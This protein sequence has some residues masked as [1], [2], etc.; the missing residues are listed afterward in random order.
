MT[1][2]RIAYEAINLSR[3]QKDSPHNDEFLKDPLQGFNCRG[4]PG[5]LRDAQGKKNYYSQIA[6]LAESIA[7]RA[8]FWTTLGAKMT[9]KSH[10]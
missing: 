9:P 5:R 2:M 6:I 8:D 1:W 4:R 7:P 3:L 10:L